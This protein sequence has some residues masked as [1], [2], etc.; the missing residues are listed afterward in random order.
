[1]LQQLVSKTFKS[2]TSPQKSEHCW[3]WYEELR[4]STWDRCVWAVN[5]CYSNC[6]YLT[7]RHLFPDVS[8]IT[9]ATS[10]LKEFIPLKKWAFGRLF[11]PTAVR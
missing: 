1:M 10:L 3:G 5:D 2:Q 6:L 11:L 4:G 9:N 7:L 8:P